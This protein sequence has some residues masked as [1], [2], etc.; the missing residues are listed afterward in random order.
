MFSMPL[1]PLAGV[2]LFI[3]AGALVMHACSVARAVVLH[4]VA[5]R[6]VISEG[7][8]VIIRATVM[9]SRSDSGVR[10]AK[11]KLWPYVNGRQW[12]AAEEANRSGDTTF[13]IPVPNTGTARI[14]VAASRPKEAVFPVGRPMPGGALNSNTVVVTVKARKVIMPV[15]RRHLVG[16][17]Y[18]PWFTP[19]NMTWNTAEAVPMLG[20]YSSFNPAVIRQHALWLDQMGINYILIDW[21]N[22]LW[23]KTRFSQRSPGAKQLTAATTLL[24]KTYAQMRRQGIATPEVTLLLGIDNGPVTTTTAV[25]GEIAWIYRKYIQNS[26]YAGLWLNYHKKPLIVVFNGGGPPFLAAKLA[27]DEPPINTHDFTVRWMASQL[28]NAPHFARAGYWSWMD[29]SIHPI[30]TYHGKQC[31]ALTIT[32][33][34]FADGGWLAPTARARD[35]GC[36]F[37]RELNTALR[38][39][40]HFLNICQWKEF[41]GQPIGQ[42]YGPAHNNY[43]DCYNT[44]LNND[45]EPTSLTACAYRGCGGWGFYYLNLTRACINL[46]HQKVPRTT[47]VAIGAPHRNAA[48]SANAKTMLVRWACA[49]RPP[50]SFTLLIDGS[51]AAADIN[52]AARAYTLKRSGLKPGRHDLTLLANGGISYFKLSYT[53][54]ARRLHD[55]IKTA[56]HVAFFIR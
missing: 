15:P 35:N 7:G 5:D 24:L 26:R 8:T 23:G 44:H 16:I 53:H 18:E 22:N 11:V 45:I 48:I 38:Y 1:R 52:P 51:V 9:R 31:E 12:G 41:A 54:E 37:I 4:I 49:G 28:Q 14:K 2:R 42:G 6:T 10:M 27:A 36:T 32:P 43:V 20:K 55:A 47:I 21:S 46:Y 56:A 50:R 25:N 39:R 17:D 40:P 33:A 29:G 13:I 34:F 19:L 30:P 3:I